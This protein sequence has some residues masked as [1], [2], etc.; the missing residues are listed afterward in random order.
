M[1]SVITAWSAIS[2]FGFGADSFRTGLRTGVP[3]PAAATVAAQVGPARLVPDFDARTVLGRKGTRSMDRVTA[4]AVAAVGELAGAPDA[5]GAP[6]RGP[7]PGLV[8]G[9]T[10]S[11]Q[12]TMDFTRSSL[13]GD[14]PFYVDPARF[15]NTVMNCAA[16]LSA[17]WHGLKGPN[18]TIAGGRAAGLLALNYARRLQAGG[19][20][21]TLY[22]GGVEEYSEARARLHHHGS[23]APDGSVL[24]EGA[25]VLRL[26]PAGS[27]LAERDG[28]AEVVAVESGVYE[29]AEEIPEILLGCA[30]R[31]LARAAAAPADIVLVAPGETAPEQA[32][33]TSLFGF[34]PPARVDCTG[35]I[36]DS[37]AA[38]AAFQ[39]LG[40]L[41]RAE[42]DPGLAGRL[43][44]VTAVDHDGTL[45]C[46]LLRPCSRTPNPT[47]ARTP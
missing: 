8:L 29:D 10:G 4:L 13:D 11:V 12:S 2:P 17:I 27:A 20:A 46:A 39:V 5:P 22:C 33:L 6:G 30:R 7:A 43:A 23:G 1:R 41:V 35:L 14:R 19:R 38:A 16:G 26:E 24:G 15:P 47:T 40:V 9:T 37:A 34:E 36:G 45:G 21:G 18:A 3:A 31:A 25:A 28:L 42:D 32:A 44:L